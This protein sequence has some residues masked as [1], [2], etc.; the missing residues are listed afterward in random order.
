[1]TLLQNQVA[2]KADK[3]LGLITS[4]DDTAPKRPLC[5]GPADVV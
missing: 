4:Q 1:M 2:D 3:L 5:G